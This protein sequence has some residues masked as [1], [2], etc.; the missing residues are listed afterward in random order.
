[1][2]DA[3]IE[4]DGFREFAAACR[5][6]AA[7]LGR[8]VRDFLTRSALSIQTEARKRAPVDRG[9]LRQ[10]ISTQVDYAPVPE[11]A[12]A[13]IIGAPEKSALW[14]KA[15]VMEYGSGKFGEGRNASKRPYLP[16][17]TPDLELWAKRHGFSSGKAVAYAILRAGGIMPRRYLREGF[18][19]AVPAID[20]HLKRLGKDLRD[21]WEKR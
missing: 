18:E 17:V 3:G 6:D 4:L 2:A 15:V 11:W 13:G 20:G 14:W 16:K 7:L 8:P 1:M 9:Q 5:D 10:A 12:E 21:Q 19:A